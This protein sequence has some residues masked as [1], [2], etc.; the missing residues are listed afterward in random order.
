MAAK[1]I[2]AFNAELDGE[3]LSRI[4]WKLGS[5]FPLV[6]GLNYDTLVDLI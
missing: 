3:R 4:P 1:T 5:N 2:R 6:N